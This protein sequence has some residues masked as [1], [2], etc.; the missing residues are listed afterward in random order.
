MSSSTSGANLVRY[1]F[2][3]GNT[4]S[5]QRK[6]SLVALAYATALDRADI[7]DTTTLN[8]RRVKD[9]NGWHGTFAFKDNDQVH[10]EFHVATHGYTNGKEDFTLKGASHSSEKKDSSMRRGGKVV[11]PEEDELEEY[12]DSPIAYSHL[13]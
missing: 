11:W 3:V 4:I 13:P 7:H 10:R 2:Y 8:G 12:E 5:K 1:F 9:P 6:Q